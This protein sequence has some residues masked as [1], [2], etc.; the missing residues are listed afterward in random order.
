MVELK[1]IAELKRRPPD[2]DESG[3]IE[4]SDIARVSLPNGQPQNITAPR[5]R[6][7]DARRHQHAPYAPSVPLAHRIDP[8]DLRRLIGN[9]PLGPRATPQQCVADR[10]PELV[11]GNPRDAVG[12]GQLLRLSLD[13]KRTSQI[14]LHVR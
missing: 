10:L 2:A 4:K 11:L 7:V 12:I 5:A 14:R 6:L 9:D 8:L 3:L 1:F 13:G